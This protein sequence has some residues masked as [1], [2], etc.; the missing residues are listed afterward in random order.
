MK[1]RIFVR[2]FSAIALTLVALSCTK[3]AIGV[4]TQS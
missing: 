4:Q 2:V 3:K 1:M